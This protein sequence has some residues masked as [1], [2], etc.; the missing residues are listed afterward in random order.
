MAQLH[1]NLFVHAR[2]HHE[3]AWRH[4]SASRLPLT[5]ID[6]YAGIARIAEAGL[7]DSLFFADI[8]TLFDQAEHSVKGGL[9]PLTLLAALA[10]MTSRIGLIATAS[11]T[12]TEPFNL[13]RQ[14]ASLDH[15]SRGRIGW[16]IVTSWI[17]GAERNFGQSEQS[18]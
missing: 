3:A 18:G 14:F 17:P 5:D 8:L 10:T 15:I 7:F 1:L 13:A 11:T 12:Y 9:E 4:P 6:Y 2:G 16:N